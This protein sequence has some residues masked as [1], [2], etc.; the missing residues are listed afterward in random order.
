[1]IILPD[2]LTITIFLVAFVMFVGVIAIAL[3][4]IARS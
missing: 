1:M 4:T 3:W 2:W